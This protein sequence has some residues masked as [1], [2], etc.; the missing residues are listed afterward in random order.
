MLPQIGKNDVVH[1]WKIGVNKAM[2]V[3]KNYHEQRQGIPSL[4]LG[5]A[6]L[7]GSLVHHVEDE[8]NVADIPIQCRSV[9]M[10]KFL[11]PIALFFPIFVIM[12]KYPCNI[13]GGGGRQ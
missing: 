1:H 4:R 6:L 8:V 9:S 2:A 13:R 5:R 11:R 10:K 12:C 7:C 3:V